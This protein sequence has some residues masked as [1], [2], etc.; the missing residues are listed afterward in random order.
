MR[1][2]V[3]AVVIAV[4]LLA[5]AT[6]H[7]GTSSLIMGRAAYAQSLN[8]K[9]DLAP[10]AVTADQVAVDMQARGIPVTTY[11]QLSF[12][13][14]TGRVC[15]G[16]ISYLDWADLQ[17]YQLLYGWDVVSA[18]T[19]TA[20]VTTLTDQQVYDT[21]CGSIATF[22]A[23]GIDPTDMFAYP[24]GGK[25]YDARTAGIVSSCFTW[26][27]IYGQVTNR[28]PVPAPYVLKTDSVTGAAC[29][30]PAL[31][32]HTKVAKSAGPT[33]YYTDPATITAQLN[34]TGW[35]LVQPYRFVTGS[36]GV[37]GSNPAWDC[38]GADW[39]SHWTAPPETYCYGDFLAAID[40][41]TTTWASPAMMT[42]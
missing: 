3:T 19:T 21:S 23:H 16:R 1:K 2:I 18:G 40:A 5:P 17:N 27:R 31:L 14:E 4:G 37:M 29:A 26:G 30:D 7:A 24:G 6:A 13:G 32:C 8:A 22:N 9:C 33:G 10:G 41:A 39:R 25:M 15:N 12:T 38:T 35:N 28:L 20:P 11:A 36:Y 34:G 42:R